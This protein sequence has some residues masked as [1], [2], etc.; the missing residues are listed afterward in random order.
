MFFFRRT[1]QRPLSYDSRGRLVLKHVDEMEA[2][3]AAAVAG[4]RDDAVRLAS[5]W[6]EIACSLDGNLKLLSLSPDV[7][8]LVVLADG[9]WLINARPSTL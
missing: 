7:A 4:D 8:P 9:A 1:R 5:S 2:D 6:R 3:K